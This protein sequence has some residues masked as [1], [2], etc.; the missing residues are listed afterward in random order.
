MSRT[1]INIDDKTL[2]KAM[3]LTKKKTK[4]ATINYALQELVR[5]EE[6]KGILRLVG[7][8]KWN[9]NLNEL[10]RNRI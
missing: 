7:K 5:R 2:Y 6:A 4:T 1:N 9:A 8:I 3:A 10:R